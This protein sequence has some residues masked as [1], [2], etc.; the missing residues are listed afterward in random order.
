MKNV[1]NKTYINFS[2]GSTVNPKML[3]HAVIHHPID[4]VILFGPEEHTVIHY[5]EVKSTSIKFEKFMMNH[6][7][8]LIRVVGALMNKEWNPKYPMLKKQGVYDWHVFFAQATVLNPVLVKKPYSSLPVHREIK[9]HFIS[10]NRKAHP[11]RC[12]FID[13]LHKHELQ[14]HGIIT[15]HNQDHPDPPYEFNYWE[16]SLLKIEENIDL[17]GEFDMHTPPSQFQET[18][19][20]VVCESTPDFIFLTE[21]TFIPIFN[22]RPFLIFGA[23]HI[24]A[25]LKELKFELFDEIIDYS[26]DG[27]DDISERFDLG[28]VELKKICELDPNKL[29]KLLKPKIDHNYKNLLNITRN[30]EEYVDPAIFEIVKYDV[31]GMEQ[32][33][34]ILNYG[35]TENFDNLY[36]LLI[37]ENIT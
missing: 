22:K 1:I 28:M 11:H 26:F 14:Q 36:K 21:K 16:P 30:S 9:K 18:L 27:V 20:S 34:T 10:L 29:L 32:Y 25:Y 4:R 37:Q 31:P 12:L 8:S 35:K 3:S 24:N 15:W 17:S 33:R 2:W 19:F 7:V 13:L 6:G 5:D 23:K